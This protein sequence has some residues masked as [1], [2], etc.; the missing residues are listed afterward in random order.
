[1]PFARLKY[2]DE[3]TRFI[4]EFIA[5]A[6]KVAHEYIYTY[7]LD[8]GRQ[9][10]KTYVAREVLYRRNAV[11]DIEK[12][13]DRTGDLDKSQV[14]VFSALGIDNL[15][16]RL[17]VRSNVSLISSL[18]QFAHAPADKVAS[19]FRAIFHVNVYD[20]KISPD[21]DEV[22]KFYHKDDQ[23]LSMLNSFIRKVDLGIDSVEIEKKGDE[24]D[25]YFS[26][27]G[28]DIRQLLYYQSQGTKNFFCIFPD[29]AFA[30]MTGGVALMDE[31][32]A[33]LHP[34]LMPEI[35]SWFHD[36]GAALPAQIIM[37]CH[38]AS[39]LHHLCKEEV[40]MVQKGEDGASTLY[41]LRSMKGLR[42][43]ANLYSKYLSGAFGAVPRL[44]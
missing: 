9:R 44:G 35:L 36:N 42:R 31:I 6:E 26:H 5:G 41:G 40:W 33:D 8:I 4:L 28:L 23:M 13:F 29:L 19:M 2:F 3:P 11:G 24:V 25:A 32:D 37:T 15:D 14:A 22:V 10:E 43:D 20:D 18:T 38:N 30:L 17:N 21:E 12:F 7:E 27:S 39:I 34:S 1:M 16:P